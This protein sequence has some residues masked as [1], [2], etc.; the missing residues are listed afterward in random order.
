MDGWPVHPGSL[1]SD[2]NGILPTLPR[3]RSTSLL[4]V[5]GE[6]PARPMD[7]LIPGGGGGGTLQSRILGWFFGFLG[8]WGE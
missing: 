6:A 8:Y 1:P 5:P 2:S 7:S 4:Q 3:D